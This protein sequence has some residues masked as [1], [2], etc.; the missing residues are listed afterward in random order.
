LLLGLEPGDEVIVPSYTF[1]S[2][3]TAFA[4]RG[5]RLVFVDVDPR[6]Q[7]IDPHWVEQAITPK[8]RAIVAMHYGGV[9]CDMPAL[10]AIA[11]AHNVAIIEDAAQAIGACAPDGRP[12]GTIGALGAL[13]FHDT[14]NVSSGEG[15]A[16][17]LGDAALLSRAEI[18]WEKGT[19]RS[20]FERERH[21]I[22]R[23][24][25]KYTWVDIGSSFLPS[26]ITAAL[27][28]A[29]LEDVVP[30]NEQRMAVWNRYHQALEP[31]ERAGKLQR[32]FVPAGA[33]HNGHLYYVVIDDL[34]RRNAFMTHLDQQGVGCVFHYVPLH[35][36]NGGTKYG[37]AGSPMTNT[38][39]AGDGLVRL[40]MWPGLA[41]AEVDRV[42][43]AVQSASNLHL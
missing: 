29:Q 14:K 38:M 13:S 9:S 6:T 11:K 22:N 25:D 16:I 43:S 19:D 20:R 2:T 10:E 26:E 39:R 3:A 7:N 23:A 21:N 27:L 31:L 33:R 40:P 8:T 4:M 18:L 24:G 37:R 28:K 32:P 15:G 35:N 36:S 34:E 42:V 17:I 12:L 30:I 1:T 5:A 41:D